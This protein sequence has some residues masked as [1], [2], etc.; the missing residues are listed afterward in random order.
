M[1][2]NKAFLLWFL[3]PLSLSV[4]FSAEITVGGGTGIAAGKNLY[5]INL[6]RGIDPEV[7][8]NPS[9]RSNLIE[10]GIGV[11]RFHNMG[12][13]KWIDT[14]NRCWRTNSILRVMAALGPLFP[15]K[16][17]TVCKPP[18]WMDEDGDKRLDESHLDDY[19]AW[20]AGLVTIVNKLGGAKVEWWETLNEAELGGYKK[21]E[22]GEDLAR[23]YLRCKAAMLQVDPGIRVG[24]NAWSWSMPPQA[25]VL[26]AKVGAELPFY[27]Y[28]SYATGDAK[29]EAQDI[30]DKAWTND[31]TRVRSAL[32]DRGLSLP[33]WCDEWNMFYDW[34]ADSARH[35]MVSHRGP[36]FDALY[37][38]SAVESKGVDYLLAW[39]D[40]DNTYGKMSIQF[41]RFGGGYL[42]GLY[43]RFMVGEVL[44]TATG[45]DRVVPFAVKGADGLLAISLANRSEEPKEISLAFP[46]P[47]STGTRYDLTPN[48]VVQAPWDPKGKTLTLAPETVSLITVR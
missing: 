41:Q 47:V 12:L 10:M 22:D 25:S 21:K 28:H 17:V 2:A 13:A 27:S 43:H 18:A 32:A 29:A 19:A 42:F 11:V 30:Y 48:G 46:A 3:I 8:E 7:A 40:S 37:L 45:D 39:N 6:W 35:F 1:T 26:L 33:I 5:G 9:Y 20:A 15:V 14:T 38:K 36:V 4:G 31:R 16:M 44:K 23:I 24:A 34:R